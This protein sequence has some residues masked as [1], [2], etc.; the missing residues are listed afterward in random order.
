MTE[1]VN[2]TTADAAFLFL[3]VESPN[4]QVVINNETDKEQTVKTEIL[5]DGK[6]YLDVYD[7]DGLMISSQN[8]EDAGYTYLYEADIDSPISICAYA[9][10][11]YTVSIYDVADKDGLSED[12]GFSEGLETYLYS[13]VLDENKTVRVGFDEIEN[14]VDD[15]VDNTNA[16]TE[17]M[18][19]GADADIN[20]IGNSTNK[21]DTSDKEAQSTHNA[22]DLSVNDKSSKDKEGAEDSAETNDKKVLS[23]VDETVDEMVVVKTEAETVV[24]DDAEAETKSVNSNT[25][26]EV[27]I[28]VNDVDNAESENITE[29]FVDNE[30]SEVDSEALNETETET[31]EAS[32]TE[33]ETEARTEAIE[34]KRT[35]Q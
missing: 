26:T 35:I 23:V 17:A 33:A 28:T 27:D 19:P 32:E 14:N 11:G 6:E 18:I 29:G 10:E 25:N 7:K 2:E 3:K 13:V 16:S 1:N 4:G 8:I 20:V 22:E 31:A 15:G 12:I 5:N 21:I 9:D 30:V 34:K 24:S